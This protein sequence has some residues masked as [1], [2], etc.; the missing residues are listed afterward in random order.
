MFIGMETD[1]V[2][3]EVQTE[4]Y[5]F[6]YGIIFKINQQISISLPLHQVITSHYS[7]VLILKILLSEGRVG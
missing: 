5:V 2:L 1:G 6:L 3:C 4:F 7:S